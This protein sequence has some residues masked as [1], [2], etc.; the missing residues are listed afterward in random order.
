[1]K[2][3]TIAVIIVLSALFVLVVAYI[4]DNPSALDSS[5]ESK[6]FNVSS[7]PSE[8]SNV[9]NT[10]KTKP[11]YEGYDAETVK[12]METLGKKK[13][14]FGNNAIVIMDSSDAGKIPPDPGITDV[15]IYN[16]FTAKVL[17]KHD[18]GYKYPSV[19][20]VEKVK[21]VDQEIVGTG[22]A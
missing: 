3:W 21:F 15:Y 14:F 7:G 16:I 22:L 11:Y 1:M 10:I 12:W 13:V 18:L 8:L 20:L 6:T 2:K 5:T 19:Y 9:I 17:E 4:D